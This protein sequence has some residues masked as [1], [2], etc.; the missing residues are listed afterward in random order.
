MLKLLSPRDRRFY[1]PRQLMSTKTKRFDIKTVAM[2]DKRYSFHN[3]YL[4]YE[5]FTV[6]NL[7]YIIFINGWV[8]NIIT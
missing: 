4:C 1:F 3:P 8:R 5:Y 2:F 7:K 6:V